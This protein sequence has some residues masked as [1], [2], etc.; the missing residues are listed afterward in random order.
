[1]IPKKVL[2]VTPAAVIPEFCRFSF[3]TNFYYDKRQLSL[4]RFLVWTGAERAWL[5]SI[6]WPMVGGVTKTPPT[7][8]FAATLKAALNLKF[9]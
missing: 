6:I 7:Y 1:V 5:Q 3:S 2:C 9:V 8:F 4:K